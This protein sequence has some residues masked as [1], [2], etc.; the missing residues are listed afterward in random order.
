M[1][2]E[3]AQMVQRPFNFAIVDEVDSI[4]IDEARTPL[5]IS[6]PTD[7]KSEMYKAVTLVKQ[8]D[9][10]DYEKDEKQRSVILTEDGTEKGERLL[11]SAGLLSG[12]NLYDFE[13]TQVVHHVNQALKA[14]KMFKRDIDYIVKDGK[15]IIIDEFTGRMMDGR[16]WS[17]ACIRR[18]RPRKASRS[19][20]EPDAGLDHL[21]ELFPHVSQ[22]FGHDRH[23]RDRSD[24]IP[25]HLQDERRHDPHQRAGAADRRE[26]EFY[27]NTRTSSRHRQDDP[28]A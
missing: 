5:I 24:R 3:R 10:S 1:K 18:W 28:R 6:G 20:R 22:A 14:N 9:D 4:L 16:R 15:V 13:N 8:L 21:P 27:K 17:M 7:D 25:R 12:S 23:R 2:H 11:E 26:D 19:S